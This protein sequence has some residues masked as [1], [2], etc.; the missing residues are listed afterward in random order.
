MEITLKPISNPIYHL[1][2]ELT[3]L[4]AQALLHLCGS[5][6]GGTEGPRGM[7]DRIFEVL[8]LQGVELPTGLGTGNVHYSER[9]P[10]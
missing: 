9:W 4:E 1:E 10:D 8:E 7:F 3:T 6:T 5:V 2:L